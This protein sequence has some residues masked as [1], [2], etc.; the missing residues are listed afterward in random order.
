MRLFNERLLQNPEFDGCIVP[1]A[2]GL[3]VAVKK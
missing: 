2:E 1:T 3:T